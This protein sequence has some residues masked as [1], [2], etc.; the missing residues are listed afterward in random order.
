LLK[1]GLGCARADFWTGLYHLNAQRRTEVQGQT[2]V[3]KKIVRLHDQSQ[4]KPNKNWI[5]QHITEQYMS[6]TPE[7]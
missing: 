4:E 6:F 5:I 3:R 7:M 2:E 1:K